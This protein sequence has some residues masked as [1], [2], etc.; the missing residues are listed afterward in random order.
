M[1]FIP[2]GSWI[3]VNIV[4]CIITTLLA[5]FLCKRYELQDISFTNTQLLTPI[6]LKS[7]SID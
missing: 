2:T 5:E 3:L 4:V 6:Q 7:I 1:T